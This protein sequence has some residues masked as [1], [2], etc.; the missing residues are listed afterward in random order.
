MN[1]ISDPSATLSLR[2]FT[3]KDKLADW[4]ES[5][6][7]FLELNVWT[8]TNLTSSSWDDENRKWTITVERIKDDGSKET[9]QLM[10]V[11]YH[12]FIFTS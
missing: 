8:K 10:H 4:L 1:Q 11:Q 9:R 2:I 12:G 5:Y 6:A 3:P 7:S